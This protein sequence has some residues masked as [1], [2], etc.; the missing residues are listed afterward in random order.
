VDTDA[1]TFTATAT[2][3]DV[4]NDRMIAITHDEVMAYI[5]ANVALK[6]K[7]LL[8]ADYDLQVEPKHYP[9]M[10]GAPPEDNHN[11]F[12][13]LLTEPSWLD[14]DNS[15]N[16]EQ[17]ASII[18]YTVT[19]ATEAQIYFGECS[20]MSFRLEYGAEITRDHDSC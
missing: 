13:G 6:I 8:D 15:F 16:Y 4:F 5:T 11:E 9:G 18:T 10:P 20:A 7:R 14:D 19:S 17:W 1:N 3:P 2:S 12:A